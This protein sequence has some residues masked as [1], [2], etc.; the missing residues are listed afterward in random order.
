MDLH[1]AAALAGGQAVANHRVSRVCGGFGYECNPPKSSGRHR[2]SAANVFSNP[3]GTEAV[4]PNPRARRSP[5]MPTSRRV[6]PIVPARQLI[7]SR[8]AVLRPGQRQD[9]SWLPPFMSL[10][11]GTSG[12]ACSS[13]SIDC[14]AAN[15]SARASGCLRNA[16]SKTFLRL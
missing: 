15:M 4:F 5:P 16:S 3:F 13:F 12:A 8:I 14:S 2:R 1:D 11:G 6:A 7:A 10:S 9:Q